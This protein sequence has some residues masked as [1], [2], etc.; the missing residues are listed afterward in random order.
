MAIVLRR[1][2]HRRR[3]TKLIHKQKIDLIT[4]EQEE[5][6]LSRWHEVK[7]YVFR[8]KVMTACKNIPSESFFIAKSISI[9]AYNLRSVRI[10]R[11]S[12]EIDCKVFEE[13]CEAVARAGIKIDLDAPMTELIHHIQTGELPPP[14]VE[15]KKIHLVKVRPGTSRV[16]WTPNNSSPN[17]KVKL[18][19]TT[20]DEFFKPRVQQQQQMLKNSKTKL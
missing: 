8:H 19:Q 11:W 5:E 6:I 14:K 9:E 13:S 2:D 10:P 4:F 3:K 16:E 12:H 1:Y 7:K 17:K 20:I 15:T 18:R